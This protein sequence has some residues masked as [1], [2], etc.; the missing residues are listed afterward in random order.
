MHDKARLHAHR[1]AIAAVDPLDLARNQ[2]VGNVV[3]A[4]AAIT[5]DGRA[6]KAERSHFV[7]DL[8]VEALVPIG[9]EHARQQ[10]FLAVGARAVAHHPL[11]LA[12]F[13]LEEQGIGPVEGGLVRSNGLG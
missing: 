6:E 10:L 3:N 11:L 9:F 8:A 1:R 4:G 13:L 12:Q 7:H 5:F 2:T